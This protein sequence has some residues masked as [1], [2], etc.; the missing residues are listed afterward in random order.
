[1]ITDAAFS[2]LSNLFLLTFCFI[3]QICQWSL[4]TNIFI[5]KRFFVLMSGTSKFSRFI[6]RSRVCYFRPSFNI[7]I[8]FHNNSI[9]HWEKKIF[10]KHNVLCQYLNSTWV[11]PR[12]AYACVWKSTAKCYISCKTQWTRDT[13]T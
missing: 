12:H 4:N 13:N 2:H 9:I 11:F 5:W 1:L 3:N 8:Q 10:R 7:A 6:V